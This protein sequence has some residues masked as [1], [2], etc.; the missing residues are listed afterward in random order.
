M[1]KQQINFDV[2][3]ATTKADSDKLMALLVDSSLNEI[4]SGDGDSDN[5]ANT[6]QGL[7]AR[8]FAFGYDSAGDNWDRLRA[9]NGALHVD[10]QDASITVVESDTYAEDSAHTTADTGG[11]VL[12]VRADARPTNANTDADGDYA[13]FFVNNSGE[14]YVKDTDAAALLTTIDADT[15]SILT[16]IQ[17]ITHAEDDAHVSGDSGIMPLA[18]RN[19]A[20]TALAADG[21]YIPFTTDSSGALRVTTAGSNTEY[22]EDSGHTTA[23][24]G[25]FVLTV[26]QDTLAASTDADGDYAAFKTNNVG[27]LYT[28][29]E[30]AE[31]LLTTIDA[32]TSSI[33]TNI[34][35]ITKAE[36]SVHVSGDS[37]IMSLGVRNDAGTALA[38][39]GDYIPLSM[40]SAGDV[41]VT[42]DSETVTVTATDLDIRDLSHTQDSVKIGDGTDFLEINTDGSINTNDAALANTAMATT[43]TNDDNTAGGTDLIGTDLA[44]RKYLFVYNNGNKKVYLGNSGVTT[45]TGFPL[46]PG[47]MVDMRAGAS[48]DIHAISPDATPVQD[49][50]TLELS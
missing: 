9:T 15:G 40:N 30:A 35:A 24:Q 27:E 5:V 26:R 25:A 20:G 14:L 18:V 19:D 1:A 49:I 11:Y 3:D 8:A 21:D 38:A 47:S 32:D 33:N 17:S 29:D 34:A 7:D 46:P 6:F 12:A 48:I 28:T 37:G 39:D 45:A 44:N 10:I 36:D 2:T 4:T 13:S 23:D 50:R 41:R 43:A 42:L 22:A 16:E 31:A